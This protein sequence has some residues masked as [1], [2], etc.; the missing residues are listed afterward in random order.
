MKECRQNGDD[1]GAKQADNM[2]KA[3]KVVA[4]SFY[5]VLG[6][7]WEWGR[8][9]LDFAPFGLAGATTKYGKKQVEMV[10]EFCEVSGSSPSSDTRIPS[11]SRWETPRPLR[12]ALRN[13]FAWLTPSASTFRPTSVIPVP[14]GNSSNSWTVISSPR[15]IDTQDALR[16]LTARRVVHKPLA[17]R[18]KASGFAIKAAN[19]SAVIR[20]QQLDVCVCCLMIPPVRTS[21][22]SALTNTD[23]ST[24]VRFHSQNLCHERLS[25]NTFLTAISVLLEPI[26]PL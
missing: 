15:R 19:T 9:S 14:S 26:P 10:R 21:L 18:L 23:K 5:G 1:L 8:D 6:N 2:Q 11:S 17:D 16:G 7:A 4:N 3:V 25:D 20:N 13:A 24:T 12:N 22:T